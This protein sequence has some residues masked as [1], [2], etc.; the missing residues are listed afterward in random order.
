M[1][2]MKM[3]KIMKI[4][5]MKKTTKIN[6]KLRMNLIAMIFKKKSKI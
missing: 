1:K 2:K 5:M 3:R 4:M 6:N